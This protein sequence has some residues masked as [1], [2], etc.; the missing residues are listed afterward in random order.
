[1]KK[2]KEIDVKEPSYDA[3]VVEKTYVQFFTRM[4]T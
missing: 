2:T 3:D 4:V 1:M